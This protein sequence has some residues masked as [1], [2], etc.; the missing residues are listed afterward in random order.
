MTKTYQITPSS[1][2]KRMPWKN[3]LG[4]TLEII[5]ED[6][7]QGV[8]FRISQASV[9]EDGMFSDFS[10]LQRTLVLLSGKGMTLSHSGEFSSEN[11]L[12]A[13]L[14]TA[15]FYGGDE[16]IATL[17]SGAIED[18]NIMVRKGAFK[19]HVQPLNDVCDFT[20]EVSLPSRF[21]GIYA[22]VDSALQQSETNEEIHVLAGSI[23]QWENESHV[24]FKWLR[25]KAVAIQIESQ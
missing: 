12:Q 4:E 8:L 14:D 3:G 6:D 24:A 18:L 1:S 25:G 13:P 20:F 23:I 17:H 2:F 9:V 22:L 15:C 7:E 5:R 19:A 21:K 10:G 11:V 16:S